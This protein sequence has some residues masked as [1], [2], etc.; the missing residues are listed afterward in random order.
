[1]LYRHQIDPPQVRH[2]CRN[3]RCSAQLK[4]PTTDRRNAFCCKGC[5][6]AF[7]SARCRVCEALIFRKTSRRLVCERSKCRHELER[8]PERFALPATPIA[9]LG[10]NASRKPIKTGTKISVKS[11][12]AKA[13]KAFIEHQRRASAAAI[14][15]RHVPPLNVIGGY[16]FPGAPEIDLGPI[17]MPPTAPARPDIGDGLDIPDFLKREGR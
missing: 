3:P 14:F 12:R 8:H 13:N 17:E 10:P 9:E 1:M 2:R 7:Y 6:V 15:Q 11:G 16:Q 4:D 5:E